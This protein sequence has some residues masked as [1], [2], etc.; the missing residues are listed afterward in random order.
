MITNST[1]ALVIELWDSDLMDKDDFL[2]R[3]TIQLK[4]LFMHFH[5]QQHRREIEER[6]NKK[7]GNNRAEEKEEEEDQKVEEHSHDCQAANPVMIMID[8]WF[9]LDL[10]PK[11]QKKIDRRHREYHRQLEQRNRRRSQTKKMLNAFSRRSRNENSQKK[12]YRALTMPVISDE[13][14]LDKFC[15]FLSFF[16]VYTIFLF[17]F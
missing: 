2:G 3:C 13:A 1:G 12:I 6:T 7:N 10:L 17:L 15:A 9:K 16:F 11:Y 14:I 8:D 4:D 5:Y